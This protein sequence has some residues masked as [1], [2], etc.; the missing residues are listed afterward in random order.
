MIGVGAQSQTRDKVAHLLRR[1]GLGASVAE[2][3]FYEKLGVQG[4]IDRLINYENVDEGFTMGVWETV[5]GRNERL[6]NLRGR[7]VSAW[8]IVRLLATQRPLQEKLTLF[9]HDHFAVSG[10]KVDQG[11][12]LY[13]YIETLRAHAN[14]NFLEMLKAV[15]KDP[16]MIYWLDNNTNVKG[17]P[18]ENFAREVME[19]FTMGVGNYSETDIQEAARCYTGWAFQRT[20]TAANRRN[21]TPEE[22]LEM[23]AAGT[24]LIQFLDRPNLHD[25][26]VKRILGN[27]GNFN[28]DDVAGILACRPETAKYLA[29]KLWTWFAYPN[30]EPKIVDRL[31]KVYIDSGFEVKKVLREIVATDEFWSEKCVRKLVKNPVEF[32]IGACRAIGVGSAILAGYTKP[33]DLQT[34]LPREVNGVSRS[35]QVALTNQGMELLYPPDV[36][37]WDWGTSWISSATMVERIKFSG[38]LFAGQGSL[39]PNIAGIGET[40]SKGATTSHDVARAIGKVFDSQLPDSRYDEVADAVS[41]AGGVAA[42]ADPRRAARA[43]QIAAK[44]LFAAPEFHF[45]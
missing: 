21:P 24:P 8:W 35:I 36:A 32:T 19:L 33:A 27:E 16:A 10:S 30:P 7:D 39:G 29:T 23:I 15:G 42:F 6:P 13:Q 26:G 44:V 3:D 18:N 45:C 37:G 2:L 17:K 34:P 41:K 11:V 14:G 31:A 20:R 28:G 40:V 9:W 5:A 1:F 38:P 12:M 22:T 4:T 25:N 43:F